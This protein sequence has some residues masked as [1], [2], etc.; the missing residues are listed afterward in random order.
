[1]NA[2]Q[3]FRDYPQS[4]AERIY[5]LD[6]ITVKLKQI[7]KPDAKTEIHIFTSDNDLRLFGLDAPELRGEEREQGLISRD[8]M[9][10][11][12]AGKDFTVRTI[13]DSKGFNKVGKYGRILA[14]IFL[15]I[16]GEM[17]DLNAKAI[18]LGYA[19]FAEYHLKF[20]PM[21]AV[22]TFDKYNSFCEK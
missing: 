17:V 2:N 13:L 6:T 15:E 16:D 5:D 18:E 10:G 22:E 9:R 21:Q 8:W 4:V 1:M 3:L 19:V 12:L 14:F 7:I 11:M 20:L